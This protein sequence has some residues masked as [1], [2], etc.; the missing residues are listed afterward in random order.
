MLPRSLEV[1]SG[2]GHVSVER[3]L[4][5][6][7]P[8]PVCWV[9]SCHSAVMQ[10]WNFALNK[11]LPPWYALVK[12]LHPLIKPW[13]SELSTLPQ[14]YSQGQS[15][16]QHPDDWGTGLGQTC[17]SGTEGSG[18]WKGAR[19]LRAP[20]RGKPK[21]VRHEALSTPIRLRGADLRQATSD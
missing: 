3:C 21:L 15:H 2:C 11:V 8:G 10:V 7:G 12:A 14:G 13:A 18:W 4:E 5:W 16:L 6:L 17:G 1:C 9:D 20:A 19:V